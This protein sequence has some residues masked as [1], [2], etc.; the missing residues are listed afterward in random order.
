MLTDFNDFWYFISIIY[1]NF[2]DIKIMSKFE[3]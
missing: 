1:E 2:F 3:P